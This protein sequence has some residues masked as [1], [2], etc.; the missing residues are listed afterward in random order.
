MP[1]ISASDIHVDNILYE[2]RQR[3][4]ER[5]SVYWRYY[6]YIGFKTNIFHER[7]EGLWLFSSTLE[8]NR[9]HFNLPGWQL[10]VDTILLTM[11]IRSIRTLLF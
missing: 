10:V 2:D 3:G 1:T 5:C 8:T 6:F 11:C 4:R 7:H 9:D